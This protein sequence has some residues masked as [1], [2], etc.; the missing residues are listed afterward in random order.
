MSSTEFLQQLQIG[1]VSGSTIGLL[2]VSFALIIGVTQRFH[3][4]YTATYLGAVYAGIWL[5]DHVELPIG[6]AVVFGLVIAAVL[7]LL[8]EGVVY[9]RIAARAAKRGTDTLIPIFIAALGIT[10]FLQNVVS[11]VWNT[12]PL[13]FE[14]VKIVGI[15]WGDV[16]LT[17]LDIVR[18]VVCWAII[19]VLALFLRAT[20]TGA[21]IGAVQVNAEMARVVGINVGRIFL[22]VFA[23][24]SV[25]SGVLGMLEANLGN[26]V[27]NMGFNSVF[28]GFVVAFV[29]GMERG[30]IR[31]GIV[32]LILGL[33][34]S[35]SALWISLQYGPAVVFAVL[36]AYLVLLPTNFRKVTARFRRTGAVQVA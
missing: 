8:I 31:M 29:A 15:T 23:L 24:G 28:Y 25:I 12:Q 5:E 36:L 22:L 13:S 26:A 19:L 27:P 4:A 30:P 9:R 1:I 21:R 3:V 11:W 20:R 7:G 35:L 16:Y 2:G 17:N 10:I 33:V 6:F 18:V 34:Q 14:P 32:G